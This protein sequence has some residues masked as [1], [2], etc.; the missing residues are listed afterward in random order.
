MKTHYNT[1]KAGSAKTESLCGTFLPGKNGG[2][3]TRDKARITCQRC[4]RI[5]DERQTRRAS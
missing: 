3:F 1:A 4:L 2:W 5:L